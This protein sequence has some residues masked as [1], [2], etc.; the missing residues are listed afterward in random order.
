MVQVEPGL[1]TVGEYANVVKRNPDDS[2]K[3]IAKYFA[4]KGSRKGKS[5]SPKDNRN[6]D[7]SKYG[8]LI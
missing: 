6:G 4:G 7:E 5:T 1:D 3:A 2:K 8:T